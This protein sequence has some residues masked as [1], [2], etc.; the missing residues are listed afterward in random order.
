MTN[1]EQY[2]TNAV[3]HDIKNQLSNIT[4]SLEQLKHEIPELT[5]D[6][7]YYLEIILASCKS[8]NELVNNL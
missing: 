5:T 8:I 3:K 2:A 1:D 6:T 7:E 4:L